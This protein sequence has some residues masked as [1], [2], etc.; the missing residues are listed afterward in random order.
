M[1]HYIDLKRQRK[2]LSA[3]VRHGTC[4]FCAA[5]WRLKSYKRRAFT[6]NRNGAEAPFTRLFNSEGLIQDFDDLAGRFI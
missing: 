6:T 5:N 4:K 2:H 3:V 1:P